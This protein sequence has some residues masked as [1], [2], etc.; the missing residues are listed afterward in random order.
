VKPYNIRERHSKQ[1]E[2]Y[3]LCEKDH[4]NA[5]Y[6]GGHYIMTLVFKLIKENPLSF[7]E[8]GRVI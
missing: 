5:S 4:I 3:Y 8:R 1:A 6:D 2:R 7:I